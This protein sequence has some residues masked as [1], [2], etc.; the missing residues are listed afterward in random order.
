MKT[1]KRNMPLLTGS[2]LC[3]A[4]CLVLPF[5]TGQIPEIGNMLC[6]MHLPVLLC[7]F[8]CGPWYGAAIGFIA[9]LLRFAL[10]GMPPIMPTGIAM[11]FELC[12]Y[13]L[14]AGLLYRHLPH[15]P[16]RICAALITAMLSGRIVWGAVRV[17]LMGLGSSAFTWAAFMAGAFTNAI[18]GII[19]QLVLIPVLVLALEKTLPWLKKQ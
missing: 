4:L 6:P 12:A 17:V 13:G 7:G 9:P 5:L 15:K 19:L 8:V 16:F 10:F 14:T 2:A 18:P 1:K 11:C 3:L